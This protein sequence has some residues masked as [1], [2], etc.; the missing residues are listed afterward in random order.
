MADKGTRKEGASG[1]G[2]ADGRIG[3]LDDDPAPFLNAMAARVVA[4]AFSAS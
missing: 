2:W 1:P 3:G 4:I